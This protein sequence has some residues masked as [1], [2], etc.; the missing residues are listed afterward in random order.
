MSGN[1]TMIFLLFLNI[2]A[3]S[4]LNQEGFSLLSSW[5]SNFNSSHSATFFASS[6]ATHKN[7][8]Q[9]DYIKCNCDGSSPSTSLPPLSF[10]MATSS[11]KFHVR[12][13]HV[14][15][16]QLG[17][18]LQ[19]SDRK[20]GTRIEKLSQLQLLS[21]GSNF[22]QDG[23][24]TEIRNCSKLQQLLLFDN[25]LSGRIPLEIGQLRALEIFQA[26]GNPGNLRRDPNTDV[27][28]QTTIYAANLTGEIR[29]EI[30]NCSALEKLSIRQNNISGEIPNE[31]SLL[32]NLK[33]MCLWQNNLR[34]RIPR[35]LGNC[36]SLSSID[37]LFNFLTGEIPSEL[38]LLK[39]LQFLYLQQ[40]NLSGSI[41]RSLGNCSGLIPSELSLLSNLKFLIDQF[42]DEDVVKELQKIRRQID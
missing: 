28:M 8:C 35:S 38:S 11:E 9:W 2:L 18:Q 12:L 4:A 22:L 25:Q 7:P 31:L 6:N 41:P 19:C 10:L 23:I 32:K 16:G 5:L 34:G 13:E 20:N 42:R 36:S 37:F 27:T 17:S 40:N 15:I 14:I 26:D 1:A 29:R 30:G 39:N 21:L 24:P 33:Y 3:I